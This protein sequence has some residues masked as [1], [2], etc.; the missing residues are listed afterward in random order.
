MYIRHLIL[1][2]LFKLSYP[3]YDVVAANDEITLEGCESSA[4]CACLPGKFQLSFQSVLAGHMIFIWLVTI[5]KGD[6]FTMRVARASRIDNCMPNV[7]R[8]K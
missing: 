2:V 6:K 7:Q 8:L 1:T 3:S 5:E 4:S